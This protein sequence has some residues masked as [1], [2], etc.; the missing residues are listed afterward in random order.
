MILNSL[1][2]AFNGRNSGTLTVALHD[3]PEVEMSVCDDGNGLPDAFDPEK[4]AGLGLELVM[5]LAQQIH[6]SARIQN[7]PDGGTLATIRIP[8]T[9]T[10][11]EN[12]SL[13]ASSL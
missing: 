13:K 4:G 8:A 6:G 7:H 9:D 5:G 2:H 1:K 3:G 10:Q 11:K 12:R